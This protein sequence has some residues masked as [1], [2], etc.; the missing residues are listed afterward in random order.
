M[1]L[2]AIHP[3]NPQHRL[4][5]RAVETINQGGIIVYPTDSGYALGC[6]LGNKGAMEQI[7]RIR[8]LGK[9]HNFTLMCR[10]L[11]EIATYARI[12]N[13]LFRFLKAHTP[14]PFTFVLLATRE[15]P[16][17]LQH[18]KR[19]TIGIRVSPHPVT[20][21]ILSL[22]EQPLMSV[23]LILPGKELP[24][25]DMAEIQQRLERQVDLIIDAG[26]CGT[27]PTTVVNLTSGVPVVT[28][29]GKGV[30]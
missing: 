14:G 17:R 12:D 21:A 27:K 20:R 29:V 24:L 15:V 7:R 3:K 25:N 13:P 23:T 6:Q 22:L 28:R 30:I 4:I 11:T 2:L 1:T 5:A 10:N 19:K 18:P 9:N 16:R 26:S 8:Q